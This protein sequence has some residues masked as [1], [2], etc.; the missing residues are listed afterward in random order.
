MPDDLVTTAQEA[1][2][3]DCGL[4]EAETDGNPLLL[5]ECRECLPKRIAAALRELDE[6]WCVELAVE[7][8]ELKGTIKTGITPMQAA[9]SALRGETMPDELM[10]QVREVPNTPTKQMQNLAVSLRHAVKMLQEAQ[11]ALDV[12][13][14]DTRVLRNESTAEGRK[15][16]G[17]VDRAA[18]RA[19]EWVK[20]LFRRKV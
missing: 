16:W 9:L 3:E 20:K 18:E 5:D 12:G 1:L 8:G 15:I 6:S 13:E 14:T 7:R 4:H 10:V 17:D 2:E 19:P 11:E